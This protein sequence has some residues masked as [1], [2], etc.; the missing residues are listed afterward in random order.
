MNTHE[1]TRVLAEYAFPVFAAPDADKGSKIVY[2]EILKSLPME[3]LTEVREWLFKEKKAPRSLTE[4][5]DWLLYG[6]PK[7]A[8]AIHY[9]EPIQTLIR[10]FADVESGKVSYAFKQ[11]QIRYP[12][13]SFRVQKEIL[14]LFL[15]RTVSS[16]NW[17]AQRL[18]E[19]WIPSLA[20]DLRACWESRKPKS[21]Y[22]ALAY[23]VLYHLP[24]A[25]VMTQVAA[26]EEHLPYKELCLILGN[27][28]GFVV[29]ED[30][31]SIPAWFQ[32]MAALDRDVPASSLAHNLFYYLSHL[33]DAPERICEVE[34]PCF[35]ELRDMSFYILPALRKFGATDM[36][37]ILARME[38]LASRKAAKQPVEKRMDAFLTY[39][40]FVTA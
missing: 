26:L 32:V 12:Q 8:E 33:Y 40:N 22:S 20:D 37:C 28:S 35:A 7:A 18:D 17:A 25:Y 19:V 36:L 24:K 9:N 14:R 31:L 4:Y 30:R 29:D 15:R 23:A 3:Q 2:K 10:W 11:L 38:A 27:E 1:I 6:E 39:I 16:A 34:K 5:V 21:Q 13:Q